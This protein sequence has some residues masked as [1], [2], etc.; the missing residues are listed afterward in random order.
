MDHTTHSHPQSARLFSRTEEIERSALDNTG[1]KEAADLAFPLL[2]W[3][4]AQH[5][6]AR[7]NRLKGSLPKT[8]HHRKGWI[9]SKRTSKSRN[10]RAAAP[11][12]EGQPE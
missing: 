1:I 12:R 11:Q 5:A 10:A 8:Y 2:R 3:M 4:L 9:R 6:I 7:A